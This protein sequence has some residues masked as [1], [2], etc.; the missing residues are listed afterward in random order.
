M[1]RNPQTMVILDDRDLLKQKV[2]TVIY[3]TYKKPS[4][5]WIKIN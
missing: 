3:V 1:N 2:L 5:N 4:S